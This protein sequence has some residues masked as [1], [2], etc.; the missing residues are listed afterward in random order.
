MR[1]PRTL[2]NTIL[3]VVIAA[4]ACSP[5]T[6]SFS[7]PETPSF[8]LTAAEARLASCTALPAE[9]VTTVLGPQGGT[10]KIGPHT[11]TLGKGALHNTVEI[12]AEI[13]PDNANYVKFS[14][15]GLQFDAGARLTLS[16]ANCPG[17]TIKGLS[18]VYTDDA[19]NT[20]EV[21]SSKADPKNRTVSAPLRHFS[22]YAVAY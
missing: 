10:L 22:I 2:L 8:N 1:R 11:L 7:A 17:V 16:Y 13:V 3:G 5:A 19:L 4:G 14:P 12:T 6:E 15:E 9:T 18:V 21:L 20:L